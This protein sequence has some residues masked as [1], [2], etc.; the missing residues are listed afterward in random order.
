MRA[1]A[2]PSIVSLDSVSVG[3]TKNGGEGVD[4]FRQLGISDGTDVLIGGPGEP[5]QLDYWARKKSVKVSTD[6]KANDGY[7][8]EN[9]N[10]GSDIENLGGADGND[11]FVGSGAAERFKVKG[12]NDSAKGKGG[13][14][15]LLGGPGNDRLDGGPGTDVLNGGPGRDTCILDDRS[16]KA[17]GCETKTLNFSP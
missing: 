2:N 1:T 6:G 3:S 17:K 9:D 5:D 15:H 13:D 4:Y 14:D 11:D 16:D 8:G 12:G 10:I 7:P